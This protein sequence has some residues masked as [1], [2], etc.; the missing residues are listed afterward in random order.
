[1]TVWTR[2]PKF[3]L[4]KIISIPYVYNICSLHLILGST[5]TT[6]PRR[7]GDGMDSESLLRQSV[8]PEAQTQKLPPRHINLKSTT[9]STS[10]D[11][12]R[13][14]KARFIPKEPVKGAVKPVLGGRYFMYLVILCRM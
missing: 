2:S 12:D 5:I 7:Q 8:I 13:L 11:V 4:S 14:K 9:S 1:M 10:I 3:V 6:A